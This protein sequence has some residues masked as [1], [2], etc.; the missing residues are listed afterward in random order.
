[1][2]GVNSK[3]VFMAGFVFAPSSC[4]ISMVIPKSTII[5]SLI[6]IENEYP[7]VE[8][9]LLELVKRKEFNQL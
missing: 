1:M 6:T 7:L 3:G 8:V 9:E 4:F 2:Y 5:S